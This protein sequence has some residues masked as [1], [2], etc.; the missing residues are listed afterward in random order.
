MTTNRGKG[1]GIAFLLA[2]QNY[3]GDDCVIWPMAVDNHGYPHFGVNGKRYKA[4]RYMCEM[5]HGPA[6]GPKHQA[7]HS[8]G[9]G[10]DGCVNPR[11]LRWATNKDNMADSVRLGAVRQKGRPFHKLTEEDVARIYEL[12]GAGMSYNRIAERFS[13]KGKQI[14]KIIRGEQWPGGKRRYGGTPASI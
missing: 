2:H 9:R 6:P 14:G 1:K 3:T 7:A 13:V 5:T 11:H 12:R 4:H 10:Q 8:C